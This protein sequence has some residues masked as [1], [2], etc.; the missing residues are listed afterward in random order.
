MANAK[1]DRKGL[2]LFEKNNI[3]G[4]ML[5]RTN[6]NDTN[7]WNSL[8]KFN[9]YAPYTLKIK[10]QEKFVKHKCKCYATKIE[11]FSREKKLNFLIEMRTK[12]GS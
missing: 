2:F 10:K 11:A 5:Y 6:E 7:I 9:Y 3:T 1:L 8:K 12:I 4:A